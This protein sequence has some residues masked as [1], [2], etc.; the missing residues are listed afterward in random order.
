MGAQS[1]PL[2]DG[3][4]ALRTSLINDRNR[5]GATRLV[6]SFTVANPQLRKL[7]ARANEITL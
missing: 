1:V 6:P 7:S 4:A 2:L 3:R 5:E